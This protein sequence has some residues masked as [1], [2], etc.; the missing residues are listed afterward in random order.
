MGYTQGVQGGTCTVGCI[1][2]VVP[3]CIPPYMPPYHHGVYHTLLY[4]PSLH[5]LGI[6]HQ[7]AAHGVLPGTLSPACGVCREEALGSTREKPVGR[8]ASQPLRTLILL[9][10]VW[11]LRV[12]PS[13]S[14]VNN[15]QRS[16]RRRDNPRYIPYPHGINHTFSSKPVK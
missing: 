6:P 4:M 9:G 16:D 12:S 11:S 3:G 8:E 14:Q 10:L 1:P 15:C 2:R 7:H 13:G 5:T